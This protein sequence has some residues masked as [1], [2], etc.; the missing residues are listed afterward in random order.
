M[1]LKLGDQMGDFFICW[2]VDSID[3][4]LYGT[5]WKYI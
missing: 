5:E 1:A 4:L 2:H 3:V